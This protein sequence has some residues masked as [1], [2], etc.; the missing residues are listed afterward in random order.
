MVRV[1]YQIAPDDGTWD[2]ES[3]VVVRSGFVQRQ[4]PDVIIAL[5]NKGSSS[6]H[7]LKPQI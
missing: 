4:N 3:D 2:L 7:Q 1:W 5:L 6:A